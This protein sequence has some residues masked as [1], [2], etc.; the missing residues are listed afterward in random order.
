MYPLGLLVP[1]KQKLKEEVLLGLNAEHAVSV[2]PPPPPS[3]ERTHHSQGP[4]SRIPLLSAHDS[5]LAQFRSF[6]Q[7][8]TGKAV[9]RVW[10]PQAPK[11]GSQE[12]GRDEHTA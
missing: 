7:L 6:P 2:V 1:S 9:M 5:H 12:Q 8:H 10:P 11:D 4:E 3:L